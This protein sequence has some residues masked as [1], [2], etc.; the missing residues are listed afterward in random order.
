MD[1]R[2]AKTQ[3]LAS[4]VEIYNHSVLNSHATFDV[5]LQ[6]V[7]SR[8][9]WFEKFKET[10]PYRLLVAEDQ[11]KILGFASSSRYRDHFSFDQSVEASVY[12][13]PEAKGKGLGSA[14]YVA[15][16]E[17]LKKENIHMVLAGVALPNE[18][19]LALHRKFGFQEVGVFKDYAVKNGLRISSMWL[20]KNLQ[21][22]EHSQGEDPVLRTDRLILRQAQISDIDEI[23][24]Y[25]RDNEKHLGP[26]S[27]PK[28]KDF[29]TRK[30]W[31]ERIQ[32]HH[33]NFAK[34]QDLRLF[35]FARED[36]KS[37]IAI[38]ELSQIF[39]G[40][41]QACY[42][43]YGIAKAFEG[44][45]LMF[46]ATKATI[47]FAFNELNLH[48]LMAN[49]IPNNQRSA[50]LLAR[51]GFQQEGVAKD[52]LWLNGVWRDHVLTSLINPNWVEKK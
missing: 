41:F 24:R 4:I 36:N 38:L 28:P 12:I 45:G 47:Q 13:A 42:L 22:P 40:P 31:R 33:E 5:E 1:I 11:G 32:K 15:L 29:Y 48:R 50:R 43:G 52:Y 25:F 34:G 46:E 16:F 14:I 6:S 27:P 19:S 44:Q 30:F 9:S 10:G 20:Q 17:I 35:A 2:S 23:I 39:R 18:A 37:L 8:K 51:L 21:D 49:H 7:E 26:F 3:D